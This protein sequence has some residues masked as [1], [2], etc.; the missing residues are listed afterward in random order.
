M[1]NSIRLGLYKHFK[2]TTYLVLCVGIHTETEEQMVVYKES[3]THKVYVRPLGMFTETVVDPV[4]GEV[5]PRFKHITSLD[6]KQTK[7]KT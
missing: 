4:S 3:G 7:G 5:V 2:G 1:D 6:T